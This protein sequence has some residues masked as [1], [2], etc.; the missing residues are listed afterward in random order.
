MVHD[1]KNLIFRDVAVSKDQGVRPS[2]LVVLIDLLLILLAQLLL[3][4]FSAVTS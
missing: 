2:Q 1:L 3:D 4:L